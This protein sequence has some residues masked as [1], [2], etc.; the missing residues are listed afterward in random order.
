MRTLL[1]PPV[2]Y[3]FHRS[4]NRLRE[5]NTKYILTFEVRDDQLP[6]DKIPINSIYF[7]S[8]PGWDNEHFVFK[9]SMMDVIGKPEELV[10]EKELQYCSSAGGH[11]RDKFKYQAKFSER[12]QL[13]SMP[14]DRQVLQMRFV[15]EALL[16]KVVF[17]PR[18]ADAGEVTGGRTG[19][20][21]RKAVPSEWRLIQFPWKGKEFPQQ[22]T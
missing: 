7:V 22:R 16:G 15:A 6:P 12:F 14:F 5:G 1:G 11:V 13:G 20:D 2:C 21:A 18:D 8:Q 17:R 4:K 10:H 9:W 19:K 3:T